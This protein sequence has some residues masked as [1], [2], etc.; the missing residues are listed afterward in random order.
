MSRARA[1]W[2]LLLALTLLAAWLAPESPDEAVLLTQQASRPRPAVAPLSLAGSPEVL[3]VRARTAAAAQEVSPF[4]ALAWGQPKERTPVAAE[5]AAEP[6]APPPKAPPLPFVFMGRYEQAGHSAVFLLQGEH[7]WVVRAGDTFAESY[8]VERITPGALHLRYLPL[9]E[10]Q[11]LDT[12]GP[13]QDE[14]S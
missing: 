13:L 5:P 8:K 12:R 11:V 2:L 7:S 6:Q 14:G 3:T 10:V 9:N 1:G 4:A